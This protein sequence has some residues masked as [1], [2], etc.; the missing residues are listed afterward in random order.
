MQDYPRDSAL[1][2][3]KNKSNPANWKSHRVYWNDTALNFYGA[4]DGLA[5]VHQSG[6]FEQVVLVNNYGNL[7]GCADG[8]LQFST[9]YDASVSSDNLMHF[10]LDD[11]GENSSGQVARLRIFDRALT[12]LEVA[13]LGAV[14]VPE[15]AEY[16]AVA[17]LAVLALGIWRRSRR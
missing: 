12:S 5:G 15:L 11:S 17:G 1:P 2:D 13:A 9:S 16:A 10:F 14:A 7:S 8:V 3:E 4:G 6:R